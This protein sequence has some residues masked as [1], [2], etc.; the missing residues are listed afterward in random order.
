MPSAGA[1]NRPRTNFS[2]RKP[3]ITAGMVAMT[4]SPKM[5]RLACTIAG[6]AIPM[7]P[8]SSIHQSRQK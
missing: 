5:R 6:S 8:V 2:S 4:I 3:A 7:T 1:P